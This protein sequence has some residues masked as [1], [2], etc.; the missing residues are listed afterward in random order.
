MAF[1]LAPYMSDAELAA[2]LR[3]FL[4]GRHQWAG[5]SRVKATIGKTPIEPRQW[6]RVWSYRHGRWSNYPW[7]AI[8]IWSFPEWLLEHCK[9]VMALAKWWLSVEFDFPWS[10][11]M[12]R[13][14]GITGLTFELRTVWYRCLGGILASLAGRES[15]VSLVLGK[16][17]GSDGRF[18]RAMQASTMAMVG[19][20]ND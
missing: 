19:C 7:S 4:F 1:L 6:I 8:V 20:N 3:K 15:V 16:A 10:R 5:C 14:L 2:T 9:F 17:D 11:W 18:Q 12:T 13:P